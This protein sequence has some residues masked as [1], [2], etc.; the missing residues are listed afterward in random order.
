MEI[1]DHLPALLIKAALQPD[2]VMMRIIQPLISLIQAFQI[3]FR[4]FLNFLQTVMM[5]IG[6]YLTVKHNRFQQRI[7][8]ASGGKY[9]LFFLAVIKIK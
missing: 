5:I 8:L 1:T 4:R 9:Q 3:I 2:S 7:N 6:N